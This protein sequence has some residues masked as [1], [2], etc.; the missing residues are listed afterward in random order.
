MDKEPILLAVINSK[1]PF[2]Q[3]V[4]GCPMAQRA[5][6]R[7]WERAVSAWSHAPHGPGDAETTWR[8]AISPSFGFVLSNKG[9]GHRQLSRRCTATA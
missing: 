4:T 3:G 1:K 6:N 9:P 7:A 5:C 2:Y 8:Q